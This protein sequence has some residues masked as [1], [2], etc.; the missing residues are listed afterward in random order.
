MNEKKNDS[1]FDEETFMK[2]TKALEEIRNENKET[3][4][5]L[6][7]NEAKDQQQNARM[8]IKNKTGYEP[9]Y[10]GF[11][12]Q[13]LMNDDNINNAKNII[14]EKLKNANLTGF[15]PDLQTFVNEIITTENINKQKE[16]II[17]KL[18]SINL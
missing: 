2:L 3:T 5:G 1:I 13:I 8:E 14:K 4:K 18:E 7:F 15:S 12:N 16:N 17:I 10:K 9:S 11:I 6:L